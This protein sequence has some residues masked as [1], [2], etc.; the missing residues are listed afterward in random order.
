V[1]VAVVSC[2]VIV[3]APY[4][5]TTAHLLDL[6][7]EGPVGRR[8][9]LL[10]RM[11]PVTGVDLR[12]WVRDPRSVL[13]DSD[14]V[15]DLRET[16]EGLCDLAVQAAARALAESGLT[17][18]Q[19]DCLIV[20]SVSGYR[21]PGV[22]VHLIN[23]LR[24]RPD[25]RRI[26]VAQ[27]GC[28]GGAY[29]VGRAVVELRAFPGSVTLVVCVDGFSSV[30]Q[31]GDVSIEAAI[32]A[33][34]GGDG[35]VACVVH[36]DPDAAGFRVIEARQ[37]LLYDSADRYRLDLD[38]EGLHFWSTKAAL[39]A[40][41]EALPAASAWLDWDQPGGWPLEVAIIHPG[42]TKILES[43]ANVLRLGEGALRHSYASLAEYGN[44][45]SASVL[46]VLRRHHQ[47]P[48]SDGTK[49][50]LVGL[51]PGFTTVVAKLQWGAGVPA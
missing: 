1:A 46:E 6:V 8:R 16:Y 45:S 44:M 11:I 39:A 10:E 23:T 26:P 38:K 14:L 30:L 48:P 40:V 2:P 49:A 37:H 51:G 41:G 50:V 25:V 35:A 19:V 18:G 24:L 29:A 5:L 4:A 33:G 34:L 21:M 20:T 27:I 31:P 22:D 9:S 12:T 36:E 43:V 32:W 3:P 7:A 47:D 42:S 28:A 13:S 15:R 17:A